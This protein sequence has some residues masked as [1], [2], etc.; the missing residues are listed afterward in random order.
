MQSTPLKKRSTKKSRPHR[1][2]RARCP[3]SHHNRA[4]PIPAWR[5]FEGAP[6]LCVDPAVEIEVD[7]HCH[8]SLAPVVGLF[9]GRRESDVEITVLKSRPLI[10]G[11]GVCR[12]DQTDLQDALEQCADAEKG[13]DT[14]PLARFSKS[15]RNV[16]A[17]QR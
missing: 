9:Y 13:L 7:L 8:L 16:S 12:F 17:F 14:P 15:Q 3:A 4:S 2:S 11:D 10:K 5:E 1:R 6:T